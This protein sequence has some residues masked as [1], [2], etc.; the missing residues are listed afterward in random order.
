MAE[1]GQQFQ[2]EIGREQDG[3][4]PG[5]D[6]RK[7][8]DP[9]NA[10]GIFAGARFREAHRQEASGRHQRAGQ[11][12]ERRRGPGIGR[13]A[14]PVPALFH[15]HHHH[16]DGD[17]GV[18]DQQPERDDESAKRDTVEVDSRGIHDQQDDR[19]DQRYRQRHHDA[20]APAERQEAHDQHDDQ[21]FGKGLDEFRDR[22]LDD[23][24]LVGDLRDFDPDRKLRDDGLHRALE[25]LSE[26]DD[27]GAVLHGNAETECGFAALADKK[28]RR[29]FIAA[30]DRSDVAEPKAAPF[31]LNRHRSNGGD[32]G[33][34]AGHAQIDAVRRGFDR[35]TGHDGVLLGD[36]VEN[37]L[38][39]DAERGQLGVTELD[40]DFLR[41]LADDVDLVDAGYPQQALADVLGAR[42]ELGEPQSVSTKHV[43]RRI[44]VAVFIIEVRAGD[45]RGKIAS[46]IAHLLADL[47]PKLLDLAGRCL[48]DQRDADEGH[49]GLRIALDAVEIRQL[50]K[51]LLDLVGDL[52]LHV[53]RGR[54]RPGD[55]H[56]HGLDGE[57]RIFGATEVEV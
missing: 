31:S 16:F 25:V 41:P 47:I 19:Q 39:G 46:D 44:H 37:L 8:D 43:Q 15:L 32:S 22:L 51:L 21:R 14:R 36:A 24:R 3:D 2:T 57:G 40:E 30:L 34:R 29:V 28:A 18:I 20:G 13:G 17:D 7:P 50:L 35:S 6:Q 1:V 52:R 4:D 26:R 42:L 56:D 49:A 23:V 48:V 12:R 54:T 5:G 53:R 11:H 55:L 38:R 45:A 33:E 9:E 10:A 27:V